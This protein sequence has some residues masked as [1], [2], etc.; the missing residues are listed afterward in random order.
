MLAC[1][2]L[3]AKFV[4]ALTGLLFF[5]TFFAAGTKVGNKILCLRWLQDICKGWHLATTLKNLSSNLSFAQPAAY[6]GEV[7]PLCTTIVSDGVAVQ[8]TV[9]RKR[10]LLHVLAGGGSRCDKRR[11]G[12]EEEDN[13]GQQIHWAADPLRGEDSGAKSL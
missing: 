13:R 3:A 5:I 11:A 10:P 12:C 2:D 7:G 4:N 1:K 8:A 9:F 6:S